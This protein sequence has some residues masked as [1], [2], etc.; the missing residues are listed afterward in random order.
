MENKILSFQELP[1]S[2]VGALYVQYEDY[3][4]SCDDEDS[5]C[6]GDLLTF[7]DFVN[8]NSIEMK[9]NRIYQVDRL[10]E[11]VNIWNP[12]LNE[13]EKFDWDLFIDL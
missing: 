13:W 11:C 9:D 3:L 8:V 7:K 4:Q 6:E 1:K 2:I 10:Y 5:E 12:N